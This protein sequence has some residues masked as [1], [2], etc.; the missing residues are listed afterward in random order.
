MVGCCFKE[1]FLFVFLGK[2]GY[3]FDLV[4]IDEGDVVEEGWV[5]GWVWFCGCRWRWEV[6]LFECRGR[7]F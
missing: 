3:V 1:V 2:V 5:V 4:V 6:I 7:C